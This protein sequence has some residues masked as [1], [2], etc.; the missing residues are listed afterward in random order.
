[1]HTY[2][3]EH[4]DCQN[5]FHQYQTRAILANLMLAKVTHYTVSMVRCKSLTEDNL[6]IS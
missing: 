1:M 2:D 3:P 4:S 5:K 6:Y